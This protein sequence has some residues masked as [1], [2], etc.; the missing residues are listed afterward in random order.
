MVKKMMK[1]G[2][3]DIHCHILPRVDDGSNST[4][5]S[6]DMLQ[7]ARKNGIKH[8]VLTPHYM[9]GRFEATRK[10]VYEQYQLFLA[11]VEEEFPDIE[12][13]FGREIFFGEDVPELLQENIIS[14][15]NDTDY[16]LVEFHPSAGAAYI[17]ESIYKVQ[18]AGYTPILA[19]IERYPELMGK[20]KMIEQVVESGAYIQVNASS[21]TGMMGNGTRR[22]LLKMIKKGLVHFVATDAHS[23]RTRAPY[24][25]E[26]VRL[27]EKKLGPEYVERLL[28]ENPRKMLANEY[29]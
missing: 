1:N 13:F 7:I 26:C 17:L 28:I 12:F 18:Q 27:L 4:G 24:L 6:K 11:R 21:L 22:Q 3:Y 20:M 25:E 5:M 14:T 29:I 16:V 9:I 23:N 2:F 15:M 8:I 19:H 10:E